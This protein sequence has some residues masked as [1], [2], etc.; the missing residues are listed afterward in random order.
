MSQCSVDAESRECAYLGWRGGHI[1]GD[2]HTAGCHAD[3]FVCIVFKGHMYHLFGSLNA[4]VLVPN[5]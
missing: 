4:V 5:G 3:G 1:S 2:Q